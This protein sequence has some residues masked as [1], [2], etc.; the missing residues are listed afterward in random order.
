MA[1]LL[2]QLQVML[3]LRP[4]VPAGVAQRIDAL[5]RTPEERSQLLEGVQRRMS[6]PMSLNLF[7]ENLARQ[8]K[9]RAEMEKAKNALREREY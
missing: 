5:A 3:G 6:N 9:S 4:N 7:L 2:E 1:G 8:Q